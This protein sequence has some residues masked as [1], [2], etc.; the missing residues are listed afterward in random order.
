MAREQIQIIYEDEHLL[1]L[2]KPSGVVVNVSHT[3]AQGTL[4]QYLQKKLAKELELADPTGEFFSRAGLVHRLDKE[5]SGVILAAKSPEDFEALKQQFMSREVVKEYVALALG[6][7]EDEI[8]EINAPIGR[9]PNKRTAMAVVSDGKPATTRFEVVGEEYIDDM[10]MTL[11]KAFPKTGRTHQIRVHLASMEHPI[12]GDDTYAGRKRSVI[13]RSRFGRLM[14]HAH[15]ITFKHPFTE[16][17]VT[18]E[19]P[20][21][22]DLK[23]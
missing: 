1:V 20:L 7:I 16:V 21:P 10:N 3:S 8:F 9:N 18:F 2:N 5:T 23:Y 11:V 13:T 6:V 12:V 14:L 4:Q 22:S 19:S 17:E 15:K